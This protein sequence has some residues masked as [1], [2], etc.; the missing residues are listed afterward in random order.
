MNKFNDNFN[1]FTKNEI[2][3]ILSYG[4]FLGWMLSFPY[5]GP[6]LTYYSNIKEL[7]SSYY[8][9]VY[10]GIPIIVLL[11]FGLFSRFEN[12]AKSISIISVSTCFVSSIYVFINFNI[13]NY[14]V[15][16]IMGISS[17]MYVVS[18][19]YFYT[20]GVNFER[21]LT[22]MGLVIIT[23]NL[24]CYL[25]N[26]LSINSNYLVS[27]LLSFLYL[28]LSIIFTLK[29]KELKSSDYIDKKNKNAGIL[30]L[31]TC[32]LLFLLNF[33]DGINYQ[34]LYPLFEKSHVITSYY[35]KIPY[36]ITIALLVIF[37]KKTNKLLPFYLAAAF[38]GLAN[39][40]FVL[41]GL[42]KSGYLITETF[43]QAGLG[44]G[45]L[46]VWTLIGQ[47]AHIYK[48]TFRIA[49]FA[50]ISLLSSVLS[51]SVLGIYLFQRVE[52]SN[53]SVMIISTSTI[54]ISLLIVPEL[55]IRIKSDLEDSNMNM[56]TKIL[57]DTLTAKELEIHDLLLQG[58]KN[59]EISSKLFIS[60]NTLKTHLKSIYH[61]LNIS[62]KV[63][64]IEA[65]KKEVL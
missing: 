37:S 60:E 33:N 35:R 52:T 2:Y 53:V 10:I 18:W 36:I 13:F 32:I 8:T 58:L 47:V 22:I 65:N 20:I 38:I 56:S 29:T 23:G 63:E 54:F 34:L 30:L 6:L 41:L 48:K 55:F 27:I 50:L 19:S 25:I 62:G 1:K 15:F 12:K 5:N 64:L 46:F 45:D 9:L 11:I 21:K 39:I 26:I 42:T 3:I 14:I 17:V 51:G 44:A 7:N 59:R 4:F 61:K 43:F 24:L 28:T 40:L 49:S 31:L 57:L 16:G